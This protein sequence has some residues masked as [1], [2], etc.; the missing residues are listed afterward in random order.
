MKKEKDNFLSDLKNKSLTIN[1]ILYKE[2]DKWI[3]QCLEFDVAAQGVTQSEAQA[4]FI[5]ALN[6]DD[7]SEIELFE[8]PEKLSNWKKKDL[9]GEIKIDLNYMVINDNLDLL[10]SFFEVEY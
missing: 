5:D 8:L 10:I 4:K 3:A 7:Q 2:D 6:I 9:I 1:C